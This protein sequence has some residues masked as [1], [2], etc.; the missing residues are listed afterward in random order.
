M[1]LVQHIVTS[2]KETTSQKNSLK[3]IT[4]DLVC[5]KETTCYVH[6]SPIQHIGNA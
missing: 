4:H 1:Y 6:S 5:R 2:F 3:F